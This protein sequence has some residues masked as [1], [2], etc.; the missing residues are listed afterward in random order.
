MHIFTEWRIE[1]KWTIFGNLVH[2]NQ[3]SGFATLGNSQSK[4]PKEDAPVKCYI[5]ELP[6][7]VNLN[8]D[9]AL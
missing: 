4:L 2:L 8:Q 3:D 1:K 9:A 6:D 7:L 5:L